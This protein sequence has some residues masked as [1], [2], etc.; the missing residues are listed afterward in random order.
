[1][2]PKISNKGDRNMLYWAFVFL[3]LALVAGFLGFVGVAGVAME[4]AK[5]LFVIFLILFVIS[6]IFGRRRPV[7]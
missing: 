6:L 3:A 5:I 1:M 4:F 7:L 2:S